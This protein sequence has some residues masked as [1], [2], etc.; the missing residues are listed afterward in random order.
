MNQLAKSFLT[1]QMTISGLDVPCSLLFSRN[2][3]L[4]SR[5]LFPFFQCSAGSL[6]YSS[7]SPI[8]GSCPY[9]QILY[10]IDHLEICRASSKFLDIIGFETLLCQ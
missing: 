4:F 10:L 7:L 8:S 3:L 5:N 6:Q 2:V 9:F 1:G